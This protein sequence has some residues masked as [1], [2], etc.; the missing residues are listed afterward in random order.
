[1]YALNLDLAGNIKIEQRV[2]TSLPSFFGEIGGL[3][4]FAQQA[5]LLLIGTC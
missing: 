4:D 1:M 5:I 3:R 2:V